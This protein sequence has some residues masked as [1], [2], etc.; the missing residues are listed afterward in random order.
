MVPA[1]TVS[2]PRLAFTLPLDAARLLRARQ[3]IRD[4]LYG[5]VHDR[6]AIDAVVLAVEEA[7]TNALRHSGT[8]D[9]LEIHLQFQG[10][11]LV[12]EVRDHGSGFDVDSFDP[13]RLPDLLAPSGRGLYLIGRLMDEMEL[14]SSEGLAVRVVKRDLL[15]GDVAPGP[16]RATSMRPGEQDYRDVR[17][18]AL[19][20]EIDESFVALDW[21]YRYVHLNAAG[22]RMQGR[23]LDELLGHRLWDVRPALRDQPLGR[24]IREALEL[25]RFAVIEFVSEVTC[26]WH[27]ARVYPTSS[28]LS[29]FARDIAEQKR[30]AAERDELLARSEGELAASRLLARVAMLA[31]GS[32]SM[33]EICSQVLAAIRSDLG[34]LQ[35]GSIYTLAHDGGPLRQL[36]LFGYPAAME[37]EIRE[38]A[39]SADSVVGRV[40]LYHEPF[41]HESRDEP[42]ETARRRRRLGLDDSRWLALPIERGGELVGVMSLFFAGR[43]SFD[44]DEL[45]LYRGIAAILGNAIANA[46]LFEAEVRARESEAERASRLELLHD[47]TRVA[48]SSLDTAEVA[49]HVLDELARRFDPT[50]ATI[51]VADEARGELVA[52]AAWGYPLELLATIPPFALDSD[53]ESARVY[54]SG[55]P[56]VI[57]D[58]ASRA[59][60][61]LPRAA[62]ASVALQTGRP[63]GSYVILP[64]QAYGR[65]IGTLSIFWSRPRSVGDDDLG[66]FG[67]VTHEIAVGVKNARLHEEQEQIAT[68]LQR[69]LLH[70]LPTIAGLDLAALSVPAFQPELV[71]GDFHD[72]FTARGGLVYA[73]I[74]DVMGK[75]VAA[76]GLTETVRS[77][78]RAL[79]LDG[80]APDIVLAQ[81]D[82]MVRKEAGEQL[83]SAQLLALDPASGR[84]VLA[85]AGHPP[86][87]HLSRDGARPVDQARGP[88]L[89]LLDDADEAPVLATA[90]LRLAPDDALVL[91][92]DGVIEARREGEL[93][94]ERRLLDVVAG[95]HGRTAAAIA[96]AVRDAAREF[97]GTLRDDL[98]VLVVRRCAVQ[99]PPERRAP[100]A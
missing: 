19:L 40:A 68:T 100:S 84:V 51:F 36:A 65:T 67:A 96:A 16:A 69:S 42:P 92:T 27:E 50:I 81:T 97:A 8:R 6:D 20:E 43:R 28:G 72:V 74:G 71:G 83:V 1:E 11:D 23:P 41:T 59:V 86:A 29:I 46:Q 9:D 18:R 62:L 47:M 5:H 70:P 94:G 31:S 39:V 61:D 64:L 12:A 21:D 45:G 91:S 66:V 44:D 95:L 38:F 56:L 17:Q 88:L 77:A 90:E 22:V 33:A 78:V 4:Y 55:D 63:V 35:A 80:P 15:A 82:R 79:A 93:F 58:M 37:P 53:Y 52:L 49:Q 34:E 48:V 25:G 73:L 60:A 24:A 14:T 32:L 30:M 13:D 75:G 76:A 26:R 89:G 57:E 10:D 85:S 98:E 99:E 3:R 87:I 2:P 54:R 7:M